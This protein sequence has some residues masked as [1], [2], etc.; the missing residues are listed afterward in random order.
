MAK[1][2]I[3]DDDPDFV[4]IV[5]VILESNNYEVVSAPD[6]KQ[7]LSMMRKD[8]PD[9]ILLDIMMAHPLEG[10]DVSREMMSDEELKKIPVIMVSSITDSPHAPKFP[11]DEYLP[12]D[13]W[14]AKPIQPETLLRKVK[15]YLERYQK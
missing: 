4:E 7:A 10:V 5:R 13:D 1:V 11:T 2:M 15:L 9:L 6:G 12:I 8:K 3:I 14:L